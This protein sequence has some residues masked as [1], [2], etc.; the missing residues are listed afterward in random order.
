[1]KRHTFM[2]DGYYAISGKECFDDQDE[3]YCGPAITKLAEYENLEES[4]RLV[5]LPCRIGAAIYQPGYKFT[6]CSA[7]GI[8]PKYK[9]DIDCEDC[10]HE[11]DSECYP[12]IYEGQVRKLEVLSNG[13]VL[14]YAQFK[15]K[16]DN[17]GY[18]VGLEIFLT[19]ETAELNLREV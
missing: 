4:G 13:E 14:V 6:A 5:I 12:Y 10:C 18:R 9:H 8:T 15:D 11:C 17:S 3:N 2:S 19:K 7:C 1:M 16:W